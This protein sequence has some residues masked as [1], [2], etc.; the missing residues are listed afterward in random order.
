[1]G[2]AVL[3]A[4]MLVAVPLAAFPVGGRLTWQSGGA[5]GDAGREVV[6]VERPVGLRGIPR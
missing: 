2:K 1:M 4:V 6:S 3:E 5:A